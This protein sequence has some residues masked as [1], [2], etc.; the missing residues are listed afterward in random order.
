MARGQ[1]GRAGHAVQEQLLMKLANS[2]SLA[3][4]LV[5]KYL[6]QVATKVVTAKN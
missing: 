1:P 4:E 3:Q 5:A 6:R 2:K